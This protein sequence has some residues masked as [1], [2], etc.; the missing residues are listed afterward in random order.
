[1]EVAARYKAVQTVASMDLSKDPPMTVGL[2]VVSHSRRLADAAVELALAMI[3]DDVEPT[4]VVAAGHDAHTFGTDP[5][6]IADAIAEADDGNGVVIVLDVGSAVLSTEVALRFIDEELRRRTVVCPAPLVE[7]LI[8]AVVT[9]A[10]GGSVNQVADEAGTAFANKVHQMA[11]IA[12]TEL[13]NVLAPGE[14]AGGFILDCPHGLHMRPAARL[15]TAATA[16]D[17]RVLIRNR[18]ALSAWV[19]ATSLSKVSNL[20]IRHGDSVEL[21]AIGSEAAEVMNHLLALAA[22]NFGAPAEDDP[23]DA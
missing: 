2:V 6:H 3:A 11:D 10:S 1:V 20:A 22:N 16:P 21:R 7:G 14:I 9:A 13:E 15:V 12:D 19:P 8:A 5:G 18:T 17:T 23:P 4:I